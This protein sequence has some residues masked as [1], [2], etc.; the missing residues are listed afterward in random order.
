M[1][2]DVQVAVT[3]DGVAANKVGVKSAVTESKEMSEQSQVAEA[4]SKSAGLSRGMNAG[5]NQ[6]VG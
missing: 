3:R 1:C 4:A 5:G 2:M 6:G